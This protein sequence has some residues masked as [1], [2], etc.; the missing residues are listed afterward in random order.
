V[1]RLQS[2][3]IKIFAFK[4]LLFCVV[5][6]ESLIINFLR[7]AQLEDFEHRCLGMKDEHFILPSPSA[8]AE[9]KA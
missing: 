3:F 1:K 6:E 2:C 5:G 9:L 4:M 8:F 7:E